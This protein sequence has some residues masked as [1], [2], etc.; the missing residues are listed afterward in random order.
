METLEIRPALVDRVSSGSICASEMAVAENFG[1]GN[2]VLIYDASQHMTP[3]LDVVTKLLPTPM[4]VTSVSSPMPL[5]DVCLA[6][7]DLAIFDLS[8]GRSAGLGAAAELR[9]LD[10]MVE[11][12][13]ITDADSSP[14]AAAARS[15]GIRRIVTSNQ[16]ISYWIDLLPALARLTNARRAL[17]EAEASVPDVQDRQATSPVQHLPLS[18]A[19]RQF[20]K[21]YLARLICEFR[22]HKVVA[23]RAGIPYTTLYSMLKKLDLE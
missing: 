1:D 6:K 13:F 14:I 20:R 5:A 8:A 16:P 2:R 21:A 17:S 12:L 22:S 23:S 10:E 7:F 4:N 11:C 18:E 19:E 9:S 3:I 15:L